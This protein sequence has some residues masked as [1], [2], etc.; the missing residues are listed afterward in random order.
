ML[1]VGKL[2]TSSTRFNGSQAC[3]KRMSLG[4]TAHGFESHPR[5]PINKRVPITFG[6]SLL[7]HTMVRIGMVLVRLSSVNALDLN[8][9]K[10]ETVEAHF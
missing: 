8:K 10:D 5:I 1:S 2:L 3:F 7:E 6:T 9:Y 4:E